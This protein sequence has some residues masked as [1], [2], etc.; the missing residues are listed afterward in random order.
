MTGQNPSST[1]Q[2]YNKV[3]ESLVSDQ[4][5]IVGFIAY[6]LY[7]KSKQ[8][9]ITTFENKFHRRPKPDE[10]LTH[11]SCSEMPRLN[12]YRKEAERTLQFLLEQAVSEKQSELEKDF[13]SNLWKYVN[14]YE[15]PTPVEKIF[16]FC[17]S[18]FSGVFGNFLTSVI[19]IL[20][21][22]CL[23]SQVS[24]DNLN[25]GAKENIV[26]GIARV[27]GVETV[28][29]QPSVVSPIEN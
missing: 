19:V 17:M 23:S 22:Y 10:L 8:E 16:T 21:L 20:L 5:D 13:Q 9:Y 2:S 6:G 28:K 27:L 4:D 7:K 25:F 29:V 12:A 11:V 3:Y 1:P 24:K 18:A 26:S 15:P 14:N